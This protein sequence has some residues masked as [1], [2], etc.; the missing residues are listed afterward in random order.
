[1]AATLTLRVR[2]APDGRAA[3][4]IIAQMQRVEQQVFRDL[5][6]LRTGATA[7]QEGTLPAERYRFKFSVTEGVGLD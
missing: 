4:N 7:S 6:N 5:K 3:A 2:T 1:M